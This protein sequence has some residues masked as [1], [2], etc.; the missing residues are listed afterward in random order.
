MTNNLFV[1]EQEIVD[2]KK[3]IFM[4]AGFNQWANAGNV[5]SGIPNYLIENLAA[6]RLGH[7]SKGD[8]YLFQL[9][10][11]H[12]MFR[13]SVRFTEGYEVDYQMQPVNDLY[14]T[15]IDTKGLI[16]FLGTEPNQHEDVYANT[17]LDAAAQLRV[18][19]IIVIS[20]VGFEVP[21]DKERL[22]SCIY[23]LKKMKKELNEY[24]VSFSNYDRN[25]TIGMVLN[26]Y[27]RTRNIECIEMIART[28]SYQIALAIDSDK[29]AM[30]DILRRIRYMFGINLDL[31]GLEKDCKQQLSDID[32][33][34][35]KLCLDNPEIEPQ[36]TAYLEQVAK[37]FEEV[38]FIEPIKIPEAFLKGFDEPL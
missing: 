7:I 28:P 2:N 16:I 23:S 37:G 15:E 3:P 1:L 27:S 30:Y 36:I 38:K 19:R 8:F 20:G 4:I 33:A 11:S 18:Q 17:L 34:I 9:P 24:A 35:N 5:S 26:H 6:K 32:K 13:P 22:I 14:Y 21:F 31:S 10:G 29:M 12:Y 25:A